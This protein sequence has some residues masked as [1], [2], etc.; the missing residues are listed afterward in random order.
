MRDIDIYFVEY[1]QMKR[2]FIEFLTSNFIIW[3]FWLVSVLIELTGVCVT[4]GKFYIRN[5]LMLFSIIGIFTAVLFSVKNQSGRYWCAFVMMCTIFAVDLVFTVIFAATGGSLFFFSMLNLRG[6]AMT[7]VSTLQISFAFV[8]V[9]GLAISL[10]AV[11]SRYAMKY[12]PAPKRILPKPAIAGLMAAV[13]LF[14]GG[15]AYFANCDYNPSDLTYLLYSG[16]DGAYSDKGILG[17]FVSE[18]YKGTFF[19]EVPLGDTEELDGFIYDKV[20]V[21][22]AEK[23]VF[24]ANDGE[25]QVFGAAKD[26]N[27]VT[28]LAESLEWFSFM[29]NLADAGFDEKNPAYPYGFAYSF[30]KEKDMTSKQLEDMLRELYPNLY[31]LYDTSVVALNHHSREKTDVSEN[32]SIIGSYPT[33]RIINYEYPDNT[34]PFSVPNVLKALDE[35]VRSQSFHNGNATFYNRNEHHVNVLGFEKFTG[36]EEMMKTAEN[37]KIT[38]QYGN[39]IAL[40]DADKAWDKNKHNFDSE[41]IEVCKEEMFP[42]NT[43]F[44]TYITTIVMH[45]MYDFQ[46]NLIPYYKL[47]IERG[48]ADPYIKENYIPPVLGE[49]A[50][51]E[52]KAEAEMNAKIEALKSDDPDPFIHYAAAAIDF[53]R[54]MGKMLDYLENTVSEITGEPLINNT[55]I[56]IFGDHNAYY[57]ALGE[58][59]KDLSTD[60]KNGRNYTDLFRVPLMIHVGNQ[61]EQIQIKKF[62]CTVDIVPTLFDLLGIRYYNNLNYG[63]TIFDENESMLYSCSYFVFITDKLFFT[64][65]NNIRFAAAGTTKADVDS[66]EERARTLLDKTGHINRIFYHDYLSGE[67]ATEYYLRLRGLN[68]K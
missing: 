12:V 27:V 19:S 21:P 13:L 20:N 52:E 32:H 50:T 10:Y 56:T 37:N 48:I 24:N 40:E 14:H 42:S 22:T 45:G 31:K 60:G 3:A 57:Q 54:A 53:D 15:M 64:S 1:K 59:V 11:L 63:T 47:L 58:Q 39:G 46:E 29:A 18:L 67:R 34:V 41:M 6:D 5:P 8:L 55:L 35:N 44:N 61:T 9:S 28:V 36:V 23:L 2:K 30:Q 26:Y 17:N 38:A 25:K 7:A 66:A 65:I 49:N 68:Y 43:R 51:E 62:T 33:D 4:S 16:S